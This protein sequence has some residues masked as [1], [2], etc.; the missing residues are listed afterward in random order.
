MTPA[1]IEATFPLGHKLP[2]GIRDIC[3]YNEAH[4]YPISGCFELSTYGVETLKGWFHKDP[5]AHEQFLPFGR[6][7]CGD[8]YALWLHSGQDPAEAP[9]VMFGSEGELPVLAAN[10]VEFCRLL[11]LGYREVG[12]HP[13]TAPPDEHE[14]T[15]AFRDFMI[16]RHGFDIPPTAEPIIK[17]ASNATPDF[18]TFVSE[19]QN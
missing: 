1:E 15:A 6:G 8:V 12:L 5:T 19:R 16:Q 9:V 7:A 18:A 3:D 10:A 13:P 17:E 14:E 4:G 2:Q 11:C